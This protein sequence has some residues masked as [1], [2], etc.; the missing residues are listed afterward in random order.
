MYLQLVYSH[1]VNYLGGWNSESDRTLVCILQR[2]RLKGFLSHLLHKN[3][4]VLELVK[5]FE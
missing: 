5:E 2:K 1:V 4:L 3:I